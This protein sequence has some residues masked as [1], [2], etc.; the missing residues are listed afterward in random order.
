LWAGSSRR[1]S[2]SSFAVLITPVYAQRTPQVRQLQPS[3]QGS[4]LPALR[5]VGTGAPPTVV[6]AAATWGQ[7]LPTAPR[8]GTSARPLSR[9]PRRW[10]G[11]D[12]LPRLLDPD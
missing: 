1:C 2:R 7:G 3:P 6:Q 12:L 8:A 11:L 10:P 4:G 5:T 9:R